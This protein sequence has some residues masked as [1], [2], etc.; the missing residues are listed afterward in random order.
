MRVETVPLAGATPG[1]A[2][3][4]TLLHFG[5]EGAEPKAYVQAGLHADEAPGMLC[6]HHLRG[7]LGALE[8]EGKVRGH[9]MLVPAANPVGMGQFV[10][11]S[12][13]GRFALEDGGNYN[14][15]FPRLSDRAAALLANRL[16]AD[17]TANGRLVRA[18]LLAAHAEGAAPRQPAEALKSRLL[19]EALAARTVLDLH[20][21]G[22]ALTHLYVHADQTEVFAALAAC[23]G[24]VA[25]LTSR[26]SG[27]DP[28]DEAISRP[29]AAIRRSFAT[30]QLPDD[31]IACTVELRGRGDVDH[32]LAAADAAAVV[33]FLAG[34]G[35]LDLPPTPVPPPLCAPTPL[36]AMEALE[37]PCA[38][39]IVYR[40]A[41]GDRISAGEVVAEIIDPMT[42]EAVPV[43]ARASGLFFARP[44]GR[45]AHAGKRLGKIA[46]AVPF[47][48]GALLSP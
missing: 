33:T 42:G 4:L 27:G 29:W 25:M 24:A 18:A 11:G 5:D 16:G 10:L 21:D 28:F 39:L 7:L 44:A 8:A 23:L 12:H 38:G 41:L 13:Q 26:E 6:A 9:I 17:A 2:Y 14:R 45:I 40:R 36:E 3:A 46:G 20:C 37:S 48:T 31:G 32:A 47:R 19:A 43:Q 1:A 15:G 35:H 34:R 30:H 22:E